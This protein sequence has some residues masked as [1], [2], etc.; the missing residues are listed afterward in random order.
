M[1]SS[2]EIANFHARLWFKCESGKEDET[3]DLFQEILERETGLK[4]HIELSP[5][6]EGNE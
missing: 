4:V 3:L 1:S 6:G 5:K 2:L